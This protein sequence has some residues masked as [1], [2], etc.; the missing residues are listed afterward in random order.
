MRNVKESAVSNRSRRRPR[1]SRPPAQGPTTVRPTRHF[2]AVLGFLMKGEV[3]AIFKQT[4][5]RLPDD[6]A[7]PMAHWQRSLEGRGPL[8]ALDPLQDG[9]LAPLPEGARGV[10]EVIK[11]R[12]TYRVHY[13]NVA[14]Y[15]FGLVPAAALLAPQW[16]A[17][18]DYVD[19]LAKKLRPEMSVGD[20]L[21]FTMPEGFITEPIIN[22][23]EVIFSSARADLSASPIP[24]VRS[25][26]AGE[27]EIV[28]HA[29]CRPNYVQA[30]LL[31]G[32]LL[33]LNGVHKVLAL[34]R[35]GYSTVP[36]LWKQVHSLEHAGLNVQTSLFADQTF[37]GERPALVIDFLNPAVAVSLTKRTTYQVMRVQ[38][39]LNVSIV[40]S[41]D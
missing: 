2:S 36:C 10:A 31:D 4:P 6:P 19:E 26:G 35:R 14:D 30:A 7:D 25:T 33:L 22:G 39:G 20:L 13:E 32:R 28:V 15:H 3:D 16:F 12:R 1:S 17:D 34:L 5:F 40:P 38:V 24:E 27:F 21:D 18:L 23:N 9:A 37:K 8:T 29:S 11:R 41:I